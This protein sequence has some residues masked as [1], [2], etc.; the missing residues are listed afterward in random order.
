LNKILRGTKRAD[1]LVEQ[2]KTSSRFIDPLY[3]RLVHDLPEGQEWLYEV[4]F[5]GYRSLAGRD[6]T[7]VTLRS[8]RGNLFTEAI[9]QFYPR[10][11]EPNGL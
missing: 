10:T 4:K 9:P 7:G 2:P 6:S 5:D 3:A 1:L 8:R 11:S